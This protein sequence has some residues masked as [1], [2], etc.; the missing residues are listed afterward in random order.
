[1]TSDK[2][3]DWVPPDDDCRLRDAASRIIPKLTVKVPFASLF[4]FRFSKI[5]ISFLK[6]QSHVIW[7]KKI[8]V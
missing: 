8:N 4:K 1:M 6:R 7:D 2:E 3:D 5:Q